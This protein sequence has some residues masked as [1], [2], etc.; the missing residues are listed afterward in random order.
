VKGEGVKL[1]ETK[2]GRERTVSIPKDMV[3]ML[4][5]LELERKKEK[6]AA[7]DLQEWEDH[8]FI[9]GSE[10]N[11]PIRPDSIYQWWRRFTTK[12]KLK[13]IRF[14]ELRHTSATLLINEGVHAKVISERLGHGDIGTTMNIYG[15]VLR[16]ADKTA[17]QHFDNLFESKKA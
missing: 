16:E 8:F 13:H 2:N 15:H 11:R 3:D 5:K 6:L 1:K 4:E 7:G 10:T 14:H 17:A 12:N 9:F